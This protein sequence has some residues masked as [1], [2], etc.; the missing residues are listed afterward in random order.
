MPIPAGVEILENTYRD[1]IT[2]YTIMDPSRYKEEA[3][4]TYV[5][6]AWTDKK[7]KQQEGI[8]TGDEKSDIDLQ[9]ESLSDSGATDIRVVRKFQ[10]ITI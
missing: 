9:M 3:I 1:L 7:G 5:T 2:D 10:G 4:G 6:I 8:F